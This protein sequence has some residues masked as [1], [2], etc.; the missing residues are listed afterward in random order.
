MDTILNDTPNLINTHFGN[1]VTNLVSFTICTQT[2][3]WESSI[4]VVSGQVGKYWL[5]CL[6]VPLIQ[7]MA[8]TVSDFGLS[9]NG[10]TL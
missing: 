8:C 9:L 7:L 3:I 4:E 2:T 1:L 6:W 10:L 5:L